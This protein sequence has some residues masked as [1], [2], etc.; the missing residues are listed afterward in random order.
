METTTKCS[1]SF[2]IRLR[3]KIRCAQKVSK[4]KKALPYRYVVHYEKDMHNELSALC[5]K[6]GSDKGSINSENTPYPW[7]AHTYADFI[8]NRFSGQKNSIKKV[9]ECGIGTNNPNLVSSMEEKGKPGASLRVWRD[10][11]ANATV[12]GADIDQDILFEEERIKTFYLDQTSKRSV[13]AMWSE[14][15]ESDF[16]L[17]I[18]DGLHK[19]HAGVCLFENTIDKLA[20]MGTYI[21]E[22]VSMNAMLQYKDYFKGKNFHV[23]YVNLFRPNLKL[24][25][26]SLIVIRKKHS[27][28]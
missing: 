15:G 20:E 5:D 21:I 9:F 16:D 25:D 17:I 18:D 12:Y 3:K 10:Y 4:L 1:D 27:S 19:F 8:H 24:S 6:Y 23:E 22:D 14:V 2:I 13:D 28:L 26:N 7:S 11:F